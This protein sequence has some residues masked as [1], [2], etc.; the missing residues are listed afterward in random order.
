MTTSTTGTGTLTLGSALSGFQSFAASG[1]ANADIVT[2]VIEDGTAWEIGN[3]VY[4]SSGTTLSRSL[5]SSS[6]G[7]LLVLSGNAVVY[8]SVISQTIDDLYAT[9]ANLASPALT[10]NVTILDN[11]A[12]PALTVTQTGAGRAFVVEDSA[13]PDATPFIIDAVG[14]VGIGV[15]PAV[16]LDIGNQVNPQVR[17][18][19]TTNTVDLRMQALG[20]SASAV[21]GTLSNHPMAFFTNNTEKMRIDTLG[22]VGIGTSSPA[23]KFAVTSPANSPSLVLTD[24]TQSTLT[25]KHE[26][27]NFLTYDTAGTAI[28]RWVLNS[29]ERMRIDSTGAFGIG[30][31]NYGTS[32]QVLTSG[33]S[34]AAP[35]WGNLVDYQVFTAS[36]TWTK[37]AGI[38]ADA[39]VHFHVMGGGTSGCAYFRGS[40]T[41]RYVNGGQGGGGFI[42][43]VLASSLGATVSVTVGAGGAARTA[44]GSGTSTTGAIGGASSFG[45]YGPTAATSGPGSTSTAN[46]PLLFNH[47]FDGHVGGDSSSDFAAQDNVSAVYGGGGGGSNGP[48]SSANAGGSKFA[49]DGGAGA[50]GTS[51]VATAGSAPGGGGGAASS[52]S[53]VTSG[54]V[55][56]GA[57]ARGEVRVWTIG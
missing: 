42:A 52:T 25:I 40:G 8:V 27:G 45:G 43:S 53:T 36:G 6:T 16:A 5:L 4:T 44:S 29:T 18:V 37:P 21:V 17:L 2:Y 13:S 10:G 50:I 33:G 24:A 26:A 3:G 23:A 22:N 54:T 38:S 48:S 15:A 30:G 49:G 41:L 55:T 51:A 19:S 47:P 11:S 14:N 56:S 31:A 57:G 28:Q 35:S 12:S 32:G 34:G 9:K 1:V 46:A 7:S 20:G 39:V